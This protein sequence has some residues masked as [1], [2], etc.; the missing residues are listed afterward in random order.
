MQINIETAQIEE[1]KYLILSNV[2]SARSPSFCRYSLGIL[3]KTGSSDG[4]GG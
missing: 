2:I 1:N 3:G 4:G